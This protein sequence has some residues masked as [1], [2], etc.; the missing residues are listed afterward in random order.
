MLCFDGFRQVPI[1][2]ILNYR[3]VVEICSPEAAWKMSGYTSFKQY[4]TSLSL[5][6]HEMR[7]REQLDKG[8]SLLEKYAGR[9]QVCYEV[10]A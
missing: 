8:F 9:P 6:V 2:Q 3:K 5:P 7:E 4:P 10:C 1:N